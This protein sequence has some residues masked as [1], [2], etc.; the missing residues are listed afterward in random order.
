[1]FPHLK[2]NNRCSN[3]DDE[4][5]AWRINLWWCFLSCLMDTYCWGISSVPVEEHWACLFSVLWQLP[6]TLKRM[7]LKR[8]QGDKTSGG[9]CPP[10]FTDRLLIWWLGCLS[11]VP[12]NSVD[13]IDGTT[14]SADQWMFSKWQENRLKSSPC[15]PLR[16]L[17][18][19]FVAT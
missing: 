9:Y 12:I 3:T 10:S 7:Y 14:A 18:R 15:P 5:D 16:A 13:G 17:S 6:Q 4:D 2:S 11:W 19:V 1:M 8:R